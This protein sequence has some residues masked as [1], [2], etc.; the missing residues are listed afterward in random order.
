MQNVPCFDTPEEAI[1][2]LGLPM[3][4]QGELIMRSGATRP[5]QDPIELANFVKQKVCYQITYIPTSNVNLNWRISGHSRDWILSISPKLVGVAI[6]PKDLATETGF[7]DPDKFQKIKLLRDLVWSPGSPCP[8]WHEAGFSV[9]LQR[10]WGIQEAVQGENLGDIWKQLERHEQ[11]QILGDLARMTE[12]IHIRTVVPTQSIDHARW[13]WYLNRI[14]MSCRWLVQNNQ[15]KKDMADDIER[16]SKFLLS[17]TPNRALSCIHSDILFHN[18][19]VRQ[20]RSR[21]EI[22]GLIDWETASR[23]G[24]PNY[25]ALLGAWWMAGEDAPNR[26]PEVFSHFLI[27]YN[28]D[29]ALGFLWIP[30][31][32]QILDLMLKL[33]D[34]TWYLQV[35]PFTK[36]REP[37]RYKPRFES[38]NLI[39]GKIKNGQPHLPDDF[40]IRS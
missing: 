8:R 33:V 11:M 30:E 23:V 35:L 32:P 28:R 14:K 20:T 3:N 19:F 29:R 22:T 12:S 16:Q 4:D 34:L 27:S 15:I 6:L 38:L 37:Q 7:L 13:A 31:D 36:A 10:A 1:E 25:D 39:L 18:V 40:R 5:I 17:R 21:W 24:C 26:D 2:F 9:R